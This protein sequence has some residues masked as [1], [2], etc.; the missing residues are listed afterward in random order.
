MTVSDLKDLIQKSDSESVWIMTPQG[1]NAQVHEP[2][3]KIAVDLDLDCA[4]DSDYL[5]AIKDKAT[6]NVCLRA[7][8]DKAI[9]V[10]TG[11]CGSYSEGVVLEGNIHTV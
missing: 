8:K 5:V 10:L 11:V 3:H 7:T 4:E 1:N 9:D 2:S 6:G